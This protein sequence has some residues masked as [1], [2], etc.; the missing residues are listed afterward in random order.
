MINLKKLTIA[1]N[2]LLKE[3]IPILLKELIK[4]RIIDLQEKD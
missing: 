3:L 2:L 1:R 4:N